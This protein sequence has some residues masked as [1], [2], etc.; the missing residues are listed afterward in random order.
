MTC[1]VN[2]VATQRRS[3]AAVDK[4]RIE[5]APEMEKAL[6]H[7]LVMIRQGVDDQDLAAIEECCCEALGVAWGV[8]P[9]EV[10]TPVLSDF[11]IPLCQ[12]E[13]ASNE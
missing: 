7:I 1:G 8:P 4:Q 9:A 5:A 6:A 10:W 12:N 13:R 2:S 3:Q 11:D